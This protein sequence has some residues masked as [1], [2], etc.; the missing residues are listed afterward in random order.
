M[1]GVAMCMS[2]NEMQAL[3][4]LVGAHQTEDLVQVLD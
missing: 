3:R 4:L 2:K 1:P